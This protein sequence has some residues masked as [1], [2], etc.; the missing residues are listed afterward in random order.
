MGSELSGNFTAEKNTQVPSSGEDGK[1]QIFLG[2]KCPNGAIRDGKRGRAI[3][4]LYG[5]KNSIDGPSSDEITHLSSK[6][7]KKRN[8]TNLLTYLT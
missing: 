2:S 5:E 3:W 8:L 1:V 7:L 6:I 4:I